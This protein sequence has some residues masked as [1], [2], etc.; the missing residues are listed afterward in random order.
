[1]AAAAAQQEI[2]TWICLPSIDFI[3][4]VIHATRD[5]I[6]QF[7]P[8]TE[9]VNFILI[10]DDK[11]IDSSVCCAHRTANVLSLF[12]RSTSCR[13]RKLIFVAHKWKRDALN[14]AKWKFDENDLVQFL[15]L[16][17]VRIQRQVSLLMLLL[18]FN[19]NRYGKIAVKDKWD[20]SWIKRIRCLDVC[21]SFMVQF[22]S[23]SY[24]VIFKCYLVSIVHSWP[25]VFVGN[26]ISLMLF[27]SLSL[28]LLMKTQFNSFVYCFP[29]RAATLKRGK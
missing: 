16:C 27:T 4:H 8:I 13:V 15:F 22:V 28:S 7:V 9:Y 14:R 29:P 23:L 19:K 11:V 6:Y 5:D 10:C 21:F 25:T 20:N 18:Y 24:H 12:V 2:S 17:A 26:F 3:F 1:M